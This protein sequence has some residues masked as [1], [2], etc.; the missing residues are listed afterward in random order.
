[1]ST[2]PESHYERL[3]NAMPQWLGQASA[4]K[5]QALRQAKPHLGKPLQAAT[6]RQQALF[7]QATAHHWRAQNTVDDALKNLRDPKAYARPLLQNLLRQRFALN[8]DVDEVFIRLYIPLTIPWFAIRSGAARTWTVSLLDAA[9]HNF[10]YKEADAGFYE[11]D[12]TFISR[13]SATGQFTTL[14]HIRD[15]MSINAFVR[16]CRELN[17]GATYAHHLR[18]ALG[19]NTPSAGNS[20][21][22]KVDTSQRAALRAALQLADIRGDIKPDFAQVI[23]AMLEG[24]P[25]LSLGQLPVLCHTFTLLQT[26][27]CGILLFAPDLE[28]ARSS[29]RIVAYVPDDPQHPLKEYTSPL[30]FKRELTRQLRNEDYQLFFSRFV[31]HERLGVFFSGLSQRLSSINWHPPEPGAKHGMWR[32][33]PTL[34]PKL[35]FVATPIP[36]EP[37]RYL[38]RQK[39]N[40]ILNDARSQ[41]VSTANADSQA[42]WALWDSFVDIASTILNVALLVV[43]PFI[44]GLG[45]LMMGYMAYQLLTD[46]FEGV[47]DWA[48]GLT[49]E[50]L[51]HLVNVVQSIAQL[52]VFAAGSSLAG[53]AMDK[54]LSAEQRAFIERFKPVSL[55]DRSQ[56]YWQPDLGPYQQHL[57]IAPTLSTDEKG[58]YPVRGESVLPLEGRHYKV[59]PADD[60]HY[61][62]KHPTRADAY[63]PRLRHNGSGAWHTELEQPLAWDRKTLLRRL[64]PIAQ[65]LSETDCEQALRI[66]GV[67]EDTLRKMHHNSEPIPPMLEDTLVRLR[68]D[69]EIQQ[70]IQRLRSD[71]PAQYNAI[72]PQ[73]QLHLMTSFG[74]WPKDK[75]LQL[76]NARNEVVWQMGESDQPLVQIHEAQLQKGDWLK[77]VLQALSPEEL[78]RQFGERTGD[79]QLSL[80]ARTR[81]LRKALADIAER[82]RASL[83]ESRYGPSQ[84]A[85]HPAA[86][87]ILDTSPDLPASVAHHLLRQASGAELAQL[88]ARRVP[89]RLADLARA[90]LD[91]V[92]VTRAYEGQQLD[93]VQTIDSDRLALNA[94]R[95]LPGW[96]DQVRLAARH[97]S[98]RGSIW[99]EVGVEDAPLRRTLV[100]RDNGRY[101]AYDDDTALCAETDLYSAI[102]HALPDRQR[103][104]LGIQIDQG[105]E[106]QQ[107]LRR[108]PLAR[109]EVRRVLAS[110]APKEPSTDTLKHLGSDDGYR[111]HTPSPNAP[112]LYPRARALYPALSDEQIGAL[113][114]HLQRQPGGASVR[115]TALT[116]EYQQLETELHSWQQT[117]PTEHPQTG[118]ALTPRE[119]AYERQNRQRIAQLLKRCWRRGTEL[120]DYFEDPSRD[121]YMLRLDFPIIGELPTLNANFEHVSLLSISG[122][123]GTQGVTAFIN[124]FP[125]LRHLEVKDVPMDDL[126]PQLSSL[127]HLNTL[128]LSNCNITLTPASH[129]RLASMSHLQTLSLNGNPLGLTPSVEAMPELVAL[130]L[131]DTGIDRLPPGLL[132]RPEM[133]AALLN[134]NQIRDVP[135]ALFELPP[136]ASVHY[137]LSDNPL[138]R[139]NLEQVKEYYQRHGTFW[140]VDAMPVDLQDTQRLYPSMDKDEATRFIYSLPGDIE[141]GKRELARLAGELETLQQELGAW[142]QAPDLTSL[143]LA[144]RMALHVQLEKAWRREPA[145]ETRHVRTLNISQTLAGELPRLS[146]RFKHIG[147]LIMHGNG[148]P[149]DVGEFLQ[150]FPALDIL[151]I[152]HATLE[153]IPPR[154]FEL[155]TLTFLGLPDCSLK[156]S[157][158]SRAALQN[159]NRLEYLDLSQNPNLGQL[160]E[161]KA[162]PA[163]SSVLLKNVGLTQVPSELLVDVPRSAVNLSDNQITEMP[164]AAFTLRAEAASAFD[165]SGNPLSKVTLEQIKSYCQRTQESFNATAP[166]AERVRLQQ[167]YPTLVESEADRFIFRLPGDMDAITPTLARLEAE[168]AQLNTDL[169][170]WVLDVPQRHPVDNSPLD[171]AARAHQQL[172]RDN[173]KMLV[174]QAW[175]RESAEDEESLVD[176]FTHSLLLDTPVMGELPSLSARFEHVSWF[177]LTGNGTTTQVDGTLRCFPALQTLALSQCPVGSLPEPIFSMPKL[178]SLELT[179]CGIRLT[180]LSARSFNDLAALEFVDMSDN[181]LGETPDVSSLHNLSSLHLRNAGLKAM[182]EGVFQLKALHTLDLSGNQIED[183][184][185]GLLETDTV[186][187]EDSDLSNNPLSAQSLAYLREYYQRTGIDFNVPQATLDET[188]APLSPA[189][190]RPQEE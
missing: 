152:E 184:G 111:A 175:R 116:E 146:A 60:G 113:L 185:A 74:Y 103:E 46:V 48:E 112:L 71:D 189:Q 92:R 160:P 123:E 87:R 68:I 126:P 110:G 33:E 109:N 129:A 156:L 124:Q 53:I 83:F 37:W 31:P 133:Q 36:D 44:P 62:I 155:E 25:R 168:Y 176:E 102:L 61:A 27:L 127:P 38:Y 9:L 132:T 174:E 115:L 114:E 120:D 97:D 50:A 22:L 130:D 140:E 77:T 163:L 88:D 89:P 177:E 162:M 47:I 1:M 41:A 121:G 144:R 30:E 131:A 151:D 39:L 186:F 108:H 190:P 69:R 70:L 164:A 96:S 13:P 98:P 81:H 40:K 147:S 54:L 76:L 18:N 150:S 21:A 145:Q 149:M 58:L 188:G 180:P 67:S 106:L 173:F 179:Q 183:I 73:E 125:R 11:P 63:R 104:A 148:G 137:D 8:L 57:D 165:L 79:P 2:P 101:V 138:S 6:A 64:G 24:A 134:G 157:D 16:L 170:Q 19:L 5:H 78:S 143:E 93:S 4:A 7:K 85:N 141:A 17:L 182:P 12:S 52:G 82:K 90:A 72:D 32:K 45:E 107:R 142:S 135:A 158:T 34:D 43:T 167:L 56:R 29:Q 80:E 84:T 59:E 49:D 159:M 94:L 55:A 117:V 99:N 51:T 35:Q 172:L 105:A 86:Q 26:P 28:Q 20:L 23:S 10:D 15:V 161:F 136:E 171:D 91:E 166:E 95:L 139:A 153:D 178:A 154:I 118:V 100:R 3:K 65:G 187:H 42:R 122:N 66:S 128:G 75:T 169:D 14:P 181:P 119:Q